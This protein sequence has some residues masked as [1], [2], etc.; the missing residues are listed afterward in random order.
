MRT[1]TVRPQ[2][3]FEFTLLYLQCIDS[4]NLMKL[5]K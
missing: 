4:S 3:P 1:A 2:R 5:A